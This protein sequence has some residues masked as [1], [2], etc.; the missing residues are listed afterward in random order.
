MVSTVALNPVLD[1]AQEEHSLAAV[2]AQVAQGD[3]RSLGQ[4]YD[5]T[6]RLVYGLALRIL[7]DAGAAE[8]VTMEVFMQVWRTAESYQAGRGSVSAWLVTLARSRSIDWLR[9]KRGRSQELEHPLDEVTGL[10]DS[11]PTPESTSIVAGRTRIVHGAMAGLPAEQRHVI[12]LA[13]FSGL[14]HSEIAHR[15]ALPL[16]TVKTRIRLGMLRLREL[17]GPYAEGL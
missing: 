4:L 17:L 6:S 5:R 7:G 16:G 12:E 15:V 14:S 9:S 3:E 13:F 11:R 8:D 1:W 10:Q 2:V